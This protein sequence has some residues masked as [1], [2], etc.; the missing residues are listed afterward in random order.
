[1]ITFRPM[2][3]RTDAPE[4][5]RLY[6]YT[7]AE[8]VNAETIREWWTLRA[9]ETRI[10][11]LAVDEDLRAIGYW[12]VDRETWM[13]PG[14]FHIRVIIGPQARGHGLG[15]QMY[16]DA[17]RA[18]RKQGATRLASS[19]REG[20]A[21]S[22]RFAERHGFQVERHL[23]ESTL[24]LTT[25]DE[26]RF[27]DLLERVRA[28]GFRFFSLAEAGVSEENK[29]RLYEVN[30]AA[31]L[32]D[33]ASTGTFPDFYAF[34]KNVFEAS[35]FQADTQIL[36]SHAERWVGLAAIG[37]Y[38]AEQ[39]AYNAF[40]GVLREVR[41]RGLAQALKLQTILLARR[42]GVLCI[43]TNNDSKNAPMLAVNH[44]LGYRPEP[45][46]YRLVH[47]VE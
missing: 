10:T 5:A 2:E 4:M 24:D 46:Y 43:R 28:Q 34:S 26:H 45:G 40:T 3:I 22:L 42:A 15:T 44:K 36:A 11:M 47:V 7:V 1:M 32:D 30:R 9:G 31:A 21:A 38:P 33:P 23:F 18:A 17:L 14:L 6:S 20:D 29:L 8:P 27:E 25:F 16:A 39:R 37:I 13:K 41:G 19:V 35:W 12:D